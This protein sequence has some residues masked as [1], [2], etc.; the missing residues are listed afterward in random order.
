[1]DTDKLDKLFNMQRALQETLGFD[2]ATMSKK[3]RSAYVKEYQQH[4]DHE[5]HEMLQE[6]PFY[7]PW[8]KYN[9]AE[10]ER[11]MQLAREEFIDALHMFLNIAIALGFTPQ[12]LY[13]MFISKNQINYERQEDT[14]H[15]KKCT[16]E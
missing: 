15:Y 1:M 9:P 8:K 10:Y 2:F 5:L 14:E 4:C 7:K 3:E 12:M 11:Q 13:G 16:E 6:L